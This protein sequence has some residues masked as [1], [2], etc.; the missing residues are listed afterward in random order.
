MLAALERDNPFVLHITLVAH[1]DDLCVVPRVG[2]DLGA[3][4]STVDES[5]VRVMSVN[6]E[7]RRIQTPELR[8]AGLTSRVHC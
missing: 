6:A 2:L 3:P 5:I 1:Q 4:A 8:R 7:P